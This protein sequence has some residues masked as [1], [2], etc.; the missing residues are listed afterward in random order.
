M[1]QSLGQIP[2]ELFIGIIYD[3]SQLTDPVITLDLWLEYCES[4]K[5]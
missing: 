1:L 3:L 4:V 2:A 5:P